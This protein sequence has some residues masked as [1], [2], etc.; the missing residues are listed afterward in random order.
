MHSSTGRLFR[1][2]HHTNEG[3]E[4][5]EHPTRPRIVEVAAIRDKQT[6]V[7]ARG[8]K[9][10]KAKRAYEQQTQSHDQAQ[11]SS[12]HAQFASTSAIPPAPGTTTA[13]VATPQSLPITW[14]TQIVLFL[15][16]ASPPHANGH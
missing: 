9:F 16:C 2:Q 13:G 14:W 5:L 8:P 7:V 4:L 6:V 10:E 3:I 12:S 1:S 15:C 11:G